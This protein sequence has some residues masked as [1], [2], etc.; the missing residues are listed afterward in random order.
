MVEKLKTLQMLQQEGN[1]E[2]ELQLAA[3]IEEH[4]KPA[5]I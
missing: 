3:L 2:F 1:P 4:S 5:V